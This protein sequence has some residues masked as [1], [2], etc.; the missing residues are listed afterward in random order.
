MVLKCRG[1][2]VF[3]PGEQLQITILVKKMESFQGTLFIFF[4]GPDQK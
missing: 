2:I 4:N 1:P 3:D